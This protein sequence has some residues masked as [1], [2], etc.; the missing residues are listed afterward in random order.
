MNPA[1]ITLSELL[2]LPV[3]KEAKVISGEKGLN[4]MVKFVD[5]MEVPDVQGWLREGELLLTTAY[6]IR[7]DPTLLPK[8]VEELAKANAAA[9]AIKPERFLHD[10]PIEMLQMSNNYHLPIIQLPNNIPYM[11]ITNAVMEQIIDKQGSL[12]RRSEEIYKRLTTLVLENQGIQAVADNVA[13]LLKSSIWLVDKSGETIVQS[14]SDTADKLSSQTKFWN[15]TVDKQ[16]EGRLFIEKEALDELELICVEQARL[17]FSLELMRRKTA[18]ETEK[19]IRGDFIDELLSGLP[20]SKQVIINKGSQLGFN[21]EVDWEIAVIESDSESISLFID[22]VTVLIHQESQKLRV[23]SHVHRQGDKYILLL[24][25]KS[26]DA[27]PKHQSNLSFC[28]NEILIPFMNDWKG[29]RLG[30]GGKTQLWNINR[31]Y[32]EAK[33][34]LMIGARMNLNP[35]LFTY[36]E[37]EIL[38]LLIDASEYVDMDAYVEKRIGHLYKYDQENGMDL[39]PTLYH[40]LSTGGSLIETAK[41]LFIHRNSVKYRIDRIKQLSD[42]D[43]DNHQKRFEYYYCLVYYLLKKD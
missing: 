31:S 8:L 9:L 18:L 21:S 17:V 34:A 29:I 39:L 10:M 11:D 20:L 22:K 16:V 24:A 40:Y 25:S 35:R 30:L 7:H 13:G 19:K 36:E 5:I 12:L 6:S 3:L 26:L 27:D 15:I 37:I 28:W 14:P 4:R 23:K 41:R 1:G 33:K 43:L 2:R 32:L 42:I 38:D